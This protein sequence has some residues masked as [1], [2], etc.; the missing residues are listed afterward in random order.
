MVLEVFSLKLE[1]GKVRIHL[2]EEVLK[3]HKDSKQF[4]IQSTKGIYQ[5]SYVI[6]ACG[7]EAYPK[8]GGSNKGLELARNLDL[9]ILPTYPSLVPLNLDIY[10]LRDLSGVKL[11]V[12]I[13]LKVNGVYRG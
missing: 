3:I 10:G 4:F 12:K 7:S 5:S 6:F 13:T 2:E 9:E 1:E 8:L 11:K